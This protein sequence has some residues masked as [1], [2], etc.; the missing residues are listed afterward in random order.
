MY[1]SPLLILVDPLQR[2]ELFL[3]YADSN[4][5]GAIQPDTKKTCFCVPLFKDNCCG[6]C[7]ILLIRNK[8]LFEIKDRK[9]F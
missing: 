6:P 1:G 2:Y 9:S 3:S 4:F 8:D 7:T 5:R